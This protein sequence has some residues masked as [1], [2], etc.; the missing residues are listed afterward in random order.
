MA[1]LSQTGGEPSRESLEKSALSDT[2]RKVM[3]YM[4]RATEILRRRDVV[5]FAN[6]LVRQELLKEVIDPREKADFH[7]IVEDIRTQLMEEYKDDEDGR[8]IL[9]NYLDGIEDAA[10]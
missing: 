10:R 2:A 3:P 8:T 9:E 1:G 7:E 4:E 6:K 5:S